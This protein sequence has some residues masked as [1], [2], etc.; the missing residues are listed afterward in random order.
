M[1]ETFLL[2]HAAS[3]NKDDPDTFFYFPDQSYSYNPIFDGSPWSKLSP[4]ERETS[5]LEIAR[6]LFMLS[7]GHPRHWICSKC[8][9]VQLYPPP[10]SFEKG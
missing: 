10:S 1:D 2:L 5:E 9:I 7:T 4:N 3:S 6:L 8:N